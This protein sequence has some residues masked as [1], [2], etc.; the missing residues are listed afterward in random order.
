MYFVPPVQHIVNFHFKTSHLSSL[1]SF[2]FLETPFVLESV[3]SLTL[4]KILIINFSVCQRK[5]VEF[6]SIVF[7]DYPVAE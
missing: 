3:T 4:Y 1:T 5:Q 7:L 6:Y 2:K